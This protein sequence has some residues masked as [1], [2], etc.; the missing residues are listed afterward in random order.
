MGPVALVALVAADSRVIRKYTKKKDN[1]RRTR[2]QR[3]LPTSEIR[4]PVTQKSGV[5]P[6]ERVVTG[7]QAWNGCG[8]SKEHSGCAPPRR[9][10]Y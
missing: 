5:Y 4:K 10:D 7:F 1:E 3:F 8:D 9:L 6:L 2:L